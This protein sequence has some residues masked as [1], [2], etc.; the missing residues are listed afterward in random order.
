MQ[1]NDLLVWMDF[2]MTSIVD[3]Q[4][5]TITEVAA[6]I[7]DKDLNVIAEGPEIVIQADMDRFNHIPADVLAIHQKSGIIDRVRDS[8]TT[9][10]EAETQMLA[11]VSEYCV[12]STALLCGNSMTLDRTFMRL[13]MPQLYAYLHYRNIDV[14]AIKE[15]AKRWR[16]EFYETAQKMKEGKTHRAMD[17]IKGSIAELKFYRDNWLK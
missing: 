8:T 14:T 17:D 2:E 15:L 7:T 4:V 16:P 1:R 12:P 10:P 11:F 6:I 5:D 3:P 13:Q 9:L